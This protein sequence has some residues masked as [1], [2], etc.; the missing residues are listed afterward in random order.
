M[1]R[2]AFL[3]G[4]IVL[5]LIGATAFFLQKNGRGQRLGRPGLRI[6]DEPTY[7]LNL[8]APTN[9]P[10]IYANRSVYLPDRVLNYTSRPSPIS[11]EVINNLPKDTTYGRRFYQHED[12]GWIDYQVVLMGSD[13]TSIHPPEACLPASGFKPELSER[14][15]IR[16]ARPHAYDLP[17]TKIKLSR[18]YKDDAG[19]D[20]TVAGVFVY[21]F[22]ADGQLTADHGQRWWWMARD[23]VRSGVLQRW[24]Y[25]IC[26]SE[27]SAGSEEATYERL[28]DFIAASVPEFQIAAGAPIQGSRAKAD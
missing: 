13:R 10:E 4:V 7:S 20:V 18:T 11:T 14:D 3:V 27:C 24:A 12:E 16:I 17:V 19:N 5:A 25:V 23:L 26:Y 9:A 15:H 8:K 21:W 28:K 22:V 6:V 1:N 2:R